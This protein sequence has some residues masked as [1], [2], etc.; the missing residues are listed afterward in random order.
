MLLAQGK[1]DLA[2]AEYGKAYQGLSQERA[3]YR[4][5]VGIKLTA[6]GIDPEAGAAK[7]GE[8]K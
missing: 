2:I 5:L 1:K 8:A 4:R 3:E 6:L 7:S